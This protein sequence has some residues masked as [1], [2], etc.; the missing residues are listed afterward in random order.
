[1]GRR[2]CQKKQKGNKKMPKKVCEKCRLFVEKDV[3][4]LCQ[5]KQFTDKWKGRVYIVDAEKSLVAK[6]L[7]ITVKG[8]YAVRIK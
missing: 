7:G 8:E 1:M 4:P 2:T 6:K 5:G 3:C